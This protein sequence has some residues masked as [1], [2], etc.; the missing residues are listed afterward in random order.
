MLINAGTPTHNRTLQPSRLGRPPTSA[1]AYS[2]ERSP[3]RS[4][5]SIPGSED[6]FKGSTGMKTLPGLGG[7]GAAAPIMV[8]DDDEIDDY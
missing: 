7:A 1:S 2:P 4:V 8:V 6:T 3:S 5:T